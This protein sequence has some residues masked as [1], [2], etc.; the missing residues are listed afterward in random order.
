LLTDDHDIGEQ[1]LDLPL[2][3]V[4]NVSEQYRKVIETI[5]GIGRV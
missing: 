4:N 2:R 5:Y 1:Y 3:N